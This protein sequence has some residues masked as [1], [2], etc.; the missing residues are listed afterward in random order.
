MFQLLYHLAVRREPEVA[1][2]ARGMLDPGVTG[3]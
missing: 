1:I 2:I 3:C